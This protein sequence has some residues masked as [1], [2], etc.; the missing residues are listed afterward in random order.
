MR[1]S[2]FG[3]LDE[4]KDESKSAD[5]APAR[6]RVTAGAPVGEAVIPDGEAM[7]RQQKTDAAK[8]EEA[9][10]DDQVEV[11]VKRAFKFTTDDHVVHDITEGTQDV[12]RSWLEHPYFQA[13]G[14][15]ETEARK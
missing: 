6:R 1:N 9:A 7:L 11:F 12:P 10:A 2:K 8:R 5:P 13:H 3:A 4:A 14:V 15:R